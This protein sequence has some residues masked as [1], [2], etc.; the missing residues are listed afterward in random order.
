MKVAALPAGKGIFVDP[1]LP[2]QAPLTD[3]GGFTDGPSLVRG[4]ER[5]G[6]SDLFK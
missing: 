4:W 3:A 2:R 1:E 6:H 5:P